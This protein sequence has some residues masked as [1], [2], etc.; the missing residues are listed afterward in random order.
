MAAYSDPLEDLWY[1]TVSALV[2]EALWTEYQKKPDEPVHQSALTLGEIVA[3]IRGNGDTRKTGWGRYGPPSDARPHTIEY[4]LEN[5][6]AN[7]W[8]DYGRAENENFNRYW[9]TEK[10]VR[11]VKYKEDRKNKERLEKEARK[12]RIALYERTSTILAK[13]GISS[14]VFGKDYPKDILSI[15][16]EEIEEFV[17][18]LETRIK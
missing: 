10:H 12:N 8:V 17:H 15:R 16:I 7:K 3:Y 14:E 2:L 18:L 5:H 9:V 1:D 13:F 11:R 4:H 6:V